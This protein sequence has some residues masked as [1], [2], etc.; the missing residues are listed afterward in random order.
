[1]GDMTGI[2]ELITEMKHVQDTLV[3]DVAKLI[4]NTGNLVI[5]VDDFVE[6]SDTEFKEIKIIL[7]EGQK[8]FEVH[9]VAISD[10]QGEIKTLKVRMNGENKI[11]DA[12]ISPLKAILF[13]VAIIIIQTALMIVL[14]KKV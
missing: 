7:N 9:S 14:F 12:K 11:T 2:A 4:A 8:K 5:R 10:T 13:A 1:M 6:R 3:V